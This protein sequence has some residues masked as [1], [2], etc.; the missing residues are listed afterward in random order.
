MN[1]IK[2]L[3]LTFVGIMLFCMSNISKSFAQAPSSHIFHVNTWYMIPGQDSI[4]KAE[5]DVIL[6]EY[7]TKVTM[8]NEFVLHSS[9]MTHF[10]TDD[11]REYLIVTEYAS[12]GDMEK[13]FDRDSEL[14]RQAWP[15][16][17]QRMDYIK[18]MNSYFSY[19]KDAIFHSI[20]SLSK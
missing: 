15:D 19:H 4:V 16:V 11:S 9:S 10:F 3:L 12:M 2:L 14:E 8:K 17:K 6:K 5:R 20:P 1:K 13:A 7:H 18:K